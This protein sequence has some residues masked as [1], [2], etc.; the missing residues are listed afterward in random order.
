MPSSRIRARIGPLEFQTRFADP[1]VDVDTESNTVEKQTLNDEIII[2]KLGR[3]ADRVHIEGIVTEDQ[4]DDLDELVALE[5][6]GVRTQ[7]WSGLA[8]VTAAS[9]D[10]TQS[11]DMTYDDNDFANEW[12]Y[13]VRI[14]LLEV[15]RA[16]GPPF[17]L[18]GD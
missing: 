2:Q 8:V 3:N 15:L 16:Q 18:G 10:Y 5:E 13:E 11:Y 9:S 14:D 1:V 17:D 12:L 7:R 4:L 6:V